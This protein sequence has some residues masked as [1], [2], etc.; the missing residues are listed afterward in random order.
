MG[1]KNVVFLTKAGRMITLK[2]SSDEDWSTVIEKIAELIV[3]KKQ[4]VI[5]SLNGQQLNP[6]K[7]VSETDCSNKVIMVEENKQI[8]I[9]VRTKKRSVLLYMRV[10]DRILEVKKNL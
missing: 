5:L 3:A 1:K 6:L 2:V 9:F 8:R 10:M 4:D 7:L